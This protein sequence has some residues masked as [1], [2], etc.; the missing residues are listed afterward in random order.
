ML[1]DLDVGWLHPDMRVAFLD[2]LLLVRDGV[3]K[4][5]RHFEAV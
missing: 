2:S 5:A 4:H 3:A 1:G